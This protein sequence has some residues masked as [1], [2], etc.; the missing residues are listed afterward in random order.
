MNRKWKH[1][2]TATVS[3]V[4]VLVIAIF[5]NVTLSVL[6]GVFDLSVDFSS[7]QMTAI[8]D[9]SK[10]ILEQLDKD[11]EIII[12]GKEED[13]KSQG[14]VQVQAEQTS[15]TSSETSSSQTKAISSKRY[16]YE[17]TDSFR[18]NSD[19]ITVHYVDTRYN[20]GFFK[21]RGITMQDDTVITVYCPETR[22]YF[23]I[24]EG[25][26]EYSQYVGL[27]RRID[28]GIRSVSKDDIRTI[29]VITGHNEKTSERLVE[30]LVN[31][32][33]T[34]NFIDLTTE[35]DLK[36][37]ADILVIA[38]P[39]ISY[40]AD[41]IKKLRD[42][43]YNDGNYGKS[44][45]VFADTDMP[46][47]ERLEE[48]LEVEWGLRLE[49][50]VVI[51]KDNTIT[52]TAVEDSYMKVGY[53]DSEM[54]RN[55]AG[56]L[57]D[58]NNTL[59]VPVGK[60]RQVSAAFESKDGIQVRRLLSTLSQNAFSK[61]IGSVV[62]DSTDLSSIQ[63]TAEDESGQ[64]VVGAISYIQRSSDTE[65]QYGLTSSSVSLFGTTC[66]MDDNS[67][68]NVTGNTSATAEYM[69]NSL[70]YLSHDETFVNITAQ[71][72]LSGVLEVEDNIVKAVSIVCIAV[73]PIIC[74]VICVAVWIR[75]KNL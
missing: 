52:A 46:Q 66:F 4:I 34:V 31:N 33:Y 49:D 22:R 50:K 67:V 15:E 74:G 24:E 54:S 44:L 29:G 36:N 20:P 26:F 56:D 71:S 9:I 19:R 35:P 58:K 10:S 1:G 21:D 70:R 53:F 14:F 40:S 62:I 32:A 17:L 72:L 18:K 30:L 64:L 23:F 41:D 47:N 73:I 51:D 39:T 65:D 45:M 28:A 11:I 57:Y 42:F 69:L 75:R 25:V 59:A 8:D 27:E 3:V 61:Q 6:D 16:I 2:A 68:L 7:S 43:L 12:N 5:L 37:S 38:N 60:L 48:F 63:K 55:L 13:F